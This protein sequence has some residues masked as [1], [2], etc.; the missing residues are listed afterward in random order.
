MGETPSPV[1]LP[2]AGIKGQGVNS[3]WGQQ[4]RYTTQSLLL[5][6]SLCLLLKAVEEMAGKLLSTWSST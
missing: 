4:K 6:S 5:S 2:W 3:V 1:Q